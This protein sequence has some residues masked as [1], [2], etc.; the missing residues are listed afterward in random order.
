MPGRID[1]LTHTTTLG[2]WRLTRA[3]P[4]AELT[5]IVHEYWEVQG[6]L[7][8]FREALLPNGYVEV[9][10]NL[11][12]AHRVFEGS[13]SGVWEPSWFSGLQERSIFIESLDGTHLVSIR[14]HPLGATQ[15]FG[16]AAADGPKSVVHPDTPVRS[17]RA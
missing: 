1:E 16:L 2:T 3:E 15:I 17:P 6:R 9:M 13:S 10:V 4:C 11:G 14:L 5:G 12:P 8:P 7:S